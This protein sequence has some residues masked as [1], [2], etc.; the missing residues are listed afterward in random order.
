MSEISLQILLRT[1]PRDS[2]MQFQIR[3]VHG[4]SDVASRQCLSLGSVMVCQVVR[5]GALK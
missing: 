4:K 3:A 5:D 1:P 2:L